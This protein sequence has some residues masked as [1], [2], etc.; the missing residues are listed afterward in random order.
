MSESVIL[1]PYWKW[2]NLINEDILACLEKETSDVLFEKGG[3]FSNGGNDVRNSDVILNPGFHWF[4]GIISNYA[5]H[6]NIASGWKYQLTNV[7]TMQLARYVQGQH[8]NWHSDVNL[9]AVSEESRKLTVV[10]MLSDR[11]DYT[12]GELELQGQE[13]IVLTRGSVIAF[14]SFIFHRVTPVL[15]GVRKTATC[16]IEGPTVR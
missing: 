4:A 1:P 12:G 11:S 8:Y 9:L 13:P 5:R 15:S 3:T 16:W 6:A 7:K 2:D 14:P 10:C